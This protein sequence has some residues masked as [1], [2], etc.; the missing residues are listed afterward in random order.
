MVRAQPGTI[1]LNDRLP[2]RGLRLDEGATDGNFL[3]HFV[4]APIK[5][6]TIKPATTR[7]NSGVVDE[8]KIPPAVVPDGLELL[9]V[10]LGVADDVSPWEVPPTLLPLPNATD[11]P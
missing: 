2:C 4:L 7:S 11:K 5:A 10:A 8:L 1:V 9:A 6:M 3:F